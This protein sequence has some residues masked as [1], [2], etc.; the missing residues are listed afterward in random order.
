MLQ[1]LMNLLSLCL[2][3]FGNGGSESSVVGVSREGKDGLLWYRDFGKYGSGEFSMAVVQANQVLEDQSQIESG[4]LGTLVGVYD[5][6]G[7]PEAARYVCDH[8]FTNFQGFRELSKYWGNLMRSLERSALETRFYSHLS[9]DLAS[10]TSRN[11]SYV[12]ILRLCDYAAIAAETRGIVTVE[13]IQRAFRATEEG[14]TALVSDQWST[15]PQMATVGACCLVGVIHQQTLFIANL[16]D[17]RVVLGKKVGNTGG[18]AAIQL[19]TEHNAN[20]DAIRQELKELHPDDPN[21]VVLKHGVWRV[22]GI[23][24]VSRSIGDVYMKHARFNREPI[25]AKFRLPEPMNMP[26]MSASPTILSHLLHPNDSFLIFASDGLWE[27]LSNEKAVDIVHSNPRAGS[28]K[29]LVKAALQEA[30]RK[31][32]MRYSDLR[33]IDKKVR[34]HFHDDITVIVLFLNHDLISRGSVQNPPVSIRS[35]LEH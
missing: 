11:L 32:E 1:A 15:R 20:L 10:I 12:G 4:P 6:H 9:K 18:I 24:Q 2:R 25:Q 16:G 14:F 30:A 19:S 27:H 35:A 8:L 5:G 22:K 34:R 31:R 26:I 7:G 13:T 33:K 21:I 23:I 17:S 29:R 3:P 28:A